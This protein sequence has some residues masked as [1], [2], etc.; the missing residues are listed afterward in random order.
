MS[1][2]NNPFED[3][4][5]KGLR[6]RL[7]KSGKN[8]VTTMVFGVSMGLGLTVA[9]GQLNVG[10]TSTSARTVLAAEV[11]EADPAATTETPATTAAVSDSDQAKLDA[12]K[13]I[14]A[15][16]TTERDLTGKSAEY[17]KAYKEAFSAG[18]VKQDKSG[19]TLEIKNAA[20]VPVDNTGAEETE[21]SKG[22]VV[23]GNMFGSQTSAA[24][25]TGTAQLGDKT[26]AESKVSEANKNTDRQAGDYGNVYGEANTAY[27]P[28]T[29]PRTDTLADKNDELVNP[30]NTI[31]TQDTV[32]NTAGYKDDTHYTTA[33]PEVNTEAADILNDQG[34]I[35]SDAANPTERTATLFSNAESDGISIYFVENGDTKTR[36]HGATIGVPDNIKETT[37]V[38][39]FTVIEQAVIGITVVDAEGQQFQI[40]DTEYG[41]EG[42]KAADYTV[43]TVI[44]GKAIM[45]SVYNG[46]GMKDFISWF[47]GAIDTISTTIGDV[48]YNLLDADGQTMDGLMLAAFDGFSFGQYNYKDTDF[49]QIF[50]LVTKRN[51]ENIGQAEEYTAKLMENGVAL[52]SLEDANYDAATGVISVSSDEDIA[53]ALTS[54]VNSYFTAWNQMLADGLSNANAGGGVYHWLESDPPEYKKWDGYV[55]RDILDEETHHWS[56]GEV[57]DQATQA[58]VRDEGVTDAAIG[59][60]VLFIQGAQKVISGTLTAVDKVSNFATDILNKAAAGLDTAVAGVADAA[61]GG[62]IG[63]GQFVA[64]PI[65]WTDPDLTTQDAATGQFVTETFSTVSSLYKKKTTSSTT[66]A[67]QNVS[68]T[69]LSKGIADAT[70]KGV[71]TAVVAAAQEV[72]DNP[73]ASQMDV[74]KAFLS[75]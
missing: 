3:T 19:S 52:T 22:T 7:H 23:E 41:T 54:M 29:S 66:I 46:D 59:A 47:T 75:T 20:E 4:E 70:A 44:E 60:R 58:W 33:H 2:R 12:D 21:F 40:V 67:Y 51:I 1:F 56:R 10:V 61:I 43:G 68:K 5:K 57:W 55:T 24:E 48:A 65:V 49:T 53:T 11:D 9:A 71:D 74:D 8:W 14:T 50:G 16:K 39:T 13:D 17:T 42:S 28:A 32:V 64:V 63:I 37:T 62:G 35:S 73:N 30:I 34:A 6:Y 45:N 15:G 18:L 25:N 26:N 69:Q 31:G 27:T 36:T 72:F 38:G